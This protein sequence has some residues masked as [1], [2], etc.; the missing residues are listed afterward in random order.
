MSFLPR[1]WLRSLWGVREPKAELDAP[2]ACDA[3]KSARR[4]GKDACPEH[5]QRRTVGTRT[6]S[7]GGQ[8]DWGGVFDRPSNTIPRTTSPSLS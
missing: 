6:Y 7:I 8:V 4:A 2:L 1:K 5:H 3:C